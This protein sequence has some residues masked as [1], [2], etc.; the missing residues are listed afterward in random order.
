MCAVSFAQPTGDGSLEINTRSSV[1]ATNQTGEELNLFII[2]DRG[3]TFLGGGGGF[4][5][6]TF[7]I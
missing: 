7:E 4:P 3:N 1:N 5:G 2:V 6:I